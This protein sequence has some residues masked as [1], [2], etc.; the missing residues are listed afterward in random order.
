[1]NKDERKTIKCKLK[2]ILR[3]TVNYDNFCQVINRVDKLIHICYLFMRS[4]ILY[5]NDNQFN[6][7]NINEDFIRCAFLAISKKKKKGRKLGKDNLNIYNI[8]R[9]Y[10]IN[11]FKKGSNIQIEIDSVN[12]SHILKQTYEQIYI[13]IINNIKYNYVKYI[14]KYIK[15]YFNKDINSE[16]STVEK[17]KIKH[18][19]FNDVICKT[20]LSDKKYHLLI[21]RIMKIIP[22]TFTESTFE[23]DI[24]ENTYDYLRSML[25]MNKYF[26][27][28]ETASYQFF[29][30]K[31]TSYPGYVKIN[32]AALVEIF[33]EKKKS[34][35]LKT[36]GNIQEQERLWN[37]YFNLKDKDDKYKYFMKDYTFNYQIETDGF[38]V[39]INLIHKDAIEKKETRKENRK[40]RV[41]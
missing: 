24:I 6:N 31:K 5:A 22:N 33:C 20:K 25:N 36:T 41:V 10:Y 32:T 27:E 34:E 38:A 11:V 40:K 26:E 3:P 13:S 12:T 23:K 15:C 18:L 28:N 39:S 7:I 19:V 29:P 8:L 4:Y 9:Y 30:I 1:M 14:F 2:D 16:L 35:T 37:T 21:E 17:N